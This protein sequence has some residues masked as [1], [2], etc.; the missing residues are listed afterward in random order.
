M[1]TIDISVIPTIRLHALSARLKLTGLLLRPELRVR[2]LRHWM[3]ASQLRN[4]TG[5]GVASQILGHRDQTMLLNRCG[6]LDPVSLPEVQQTRWLLVNASS[7]RLN[8][9]WSRG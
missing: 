9:N 3:A 1:T 4:G 7:A 8:P 5:V 2:D 6:H